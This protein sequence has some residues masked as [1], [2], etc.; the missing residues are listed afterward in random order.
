MRLLDEF[1]PETTIL[2][3]EFDQSVRSHILNGRYKYIDA[4]RYNVWTEHV[5][6]SRTRAHLYM[7]RKK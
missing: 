4:R 7:S 6:D 3:G 2:I 1:P 5:G